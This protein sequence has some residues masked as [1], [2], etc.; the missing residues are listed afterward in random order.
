M[1][2]KAD[3][4]PL[5]ELECRIKGT[6]LLDTGAFINVIGK[7]FTERSGMDKHI[8]RYKEGKGPRVKLGGTTIIVG[9]TGYINLDVILENKVLIN[10]IKHRQVRLRFEV[11]DTQR[12]L[13]I[14]IEDLVRMLPIYTI[15]LF[16]SLSE[17]VLKDNQ[18]SINSIEDWLTPI[19]KELVPEHYQLATEDIKSGDLVYPWTTKMEP[20]PEDE[21][22]REEEMPSLLELHGMDLLSTFEERKE[23]YPKRYPETFSKSISEDMEENGKWNKMFQDEIN[24]TAFCFKEWTGVKMEPIKLETLESIPIKHSMPSRHVN[25]EFKPKVK[26]MITYYIERGFYILKS[27]ATV[28]GMVAVRKP[29][30]TPRICS[31]FRWVNPHIKTRNAFIPSVRES[32][33]KMKPFKVFAEMDWYKAYHQLPLQH[34]TKKLLA[35]ITPWGCIQPNFLPEGVAPASSIMQ[36][37]VDKIFHEVQDFAV[38]IADNIII[39]ANDLKDLREK[40]QRILEICTKA[41]IILSIEKSNF[42]KKTIKFFGY[43]IGE[44]SYT[45]DEE[46]RK[47]VKNIV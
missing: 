10:D 29:N 8:T 37:T 43:L 14:G 25:A 40:T 22:L 13:I 7:T 18:Q 2:I 21:Y 4:A 16:Q 30:G 1:V 44:G 5:K 36:E 12:D 26:D 42:G 15:R 19:E 31:D 39:G 46:K 27:S 41:N 3:V 17:V 20:A 32:I 47:T 24:S 33:E 45:I 28:S 23:E 34:D 9:C 6:V 38:T 35:M 11:I